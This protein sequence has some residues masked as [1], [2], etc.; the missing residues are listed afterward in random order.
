MN[1]SQMLIC[2]GRGAFGLAGAG[3]FGASSGGCG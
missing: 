3:C 1:E 2:L